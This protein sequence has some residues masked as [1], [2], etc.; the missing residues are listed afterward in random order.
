MVEMMRMVEMM[1]DGCIGGMIR[2]TCDRFFCGRFHHHKGQ[3]LVSIAEDADG[4]I[5]R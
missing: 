5:D 2:R 1:E 3:S 4:Y